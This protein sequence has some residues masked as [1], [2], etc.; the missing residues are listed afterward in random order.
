[1]S[2]DL[3]DRLK[4]LGPADKRILLAKLMDLRG[5][6]GRTAPLSYAQQRLWFLEQLI[7][8]NPFY[9][10][11]SAIRL[12]AAIDP[13][14]LQR[15]LNE[16]VRRHEALRT[17]FEAP[18][19]EPVQRVCP[20]MPVELPVIDLSHL[21]PA[22]REREA[23]R[24]CSEEGGRPFNLA[25]GPLLRVTLIKLDIGE[26]IFVLTMHHIVCDGWSMKVFFDEL[27]VLYEAMAGGQPSPLPEL[28]IQYVDFSIWQRGWLKG[29][30]L[31]Q[32]LAFW[33]M[34]LAG[35]QT[36]DL[37]TDHLRPAIPTFT[38]GRE[39]IAIAPAIYRNILTLCEQE[40][41]TPFM[42]LLASFQVLLARYSGQDD[43]AVGCPIANRNRPEVEKLIGFFVN[44]LVMRSDLSG[45]PTFRELLRR[46]R[47]VA[48]S[49]Y[50]HQDL[51]FEKLVEELQPTRD[52]SRNPLFQVTFQLLD[53]NAPAPAAQ[54]LLQTLEVGL[55]TSKFDLRCDLW[56]AGGG[57]RGHIEYSADL[58]EAETAR[59]L[60]DWL[61]ML[62]AAMA[63]SPDRRID[64]VGLMSA[65][66]EHKVLVAWN[67]TAQ[68]FPWQGC[69]HERFAAMAQAYPA[70]LAVAEGDRSRSYSELNRDAN[71]LAAELVRTGIRA[72]CLVPLVLDRSI[73]LIVAALAVL[74]AGAAYIP[75]DPTYPAAR[76]TQMIQQAMAPLVL[77]SRR[78]ID[79]VP[80]FLPR[81]CVD[82]DAAVAAIE[83]EN[84]PVLVDGRS[85]AYVIFTSGST[86]Q[87]RGVEITHDSLCNLV[88]WHQQA[89]AVTPQDRASLY[90]SPGFDASVWEIWPYLTAGASL[91]VTEPT[92]RPA[93]DALAR[94]MAG[95][96]ISISFLPTP[97]AETFVEC[98]TLP[99]LRVLLTGGDRLR[100]VPARSLPFRFVN[101]YG[102]TETTVVATCC[103]VA[104]KGSHGRNLPAIGRPIANTRAYVLDRRGRPVPPG[105]KG[106]LY[107]G[108]RSL[109]RG[110]LNGAEQTRERF[111]DD[112]FAP[113]TGERLYRTGDRVRMRHDGLLEFHGRIDSQIKLRGYRVEPGEI[114]AMLDQHPAVGKSLIVTQDDSAGERSLIAYLTPRRDPVGDAAEDAFAE[115]RVGE[116]QRIY[117]ELYDA[118]GAGRDAEFDI[119]GWNSSYTGAPLSADEMGEQV[120]GAVER[121][122]ALGGRRVLE[123]GCG[124]GLLLLRLADD[125]ERYVGTDFSAP[126]LKRL[127]ATVEARGWDHVELWER[128]AEDFGG[129]APGS[130]DVVVLNSVVQYFPDV[131][132]LVRVLREA[133]RVVGPT[134]SVFV[135]DVRH[136][137]LLPALHAEIEVR[138]AD[139]ASAAEIRERIARRGEQEQELVLD[140]AFF[141]ALSAELENC[142]GISIQI[143]RGWSHNELTRFRYDAL[144][145]GKDAVRRPQAREL[146]WD[147]IGNLAGLRRLLASTTEAVLIRGVPNA[148]LTEPCR[149][150]EGLEQADGA[151]PAAG[152]AQVADSHDGD[153]I[154]VEPEQLWQLGNDMGWDI[155]IGFAEQDPAGCDL[156]CERQAPGTARLGWS[157]TP[158][159]QK[160]PL[161]AYANTPTR[162]RT[163]QQL[164]ESLRRHLRGRLPGYMIPSSFVWLDALP[165]TPHGKL[166][167]RAL[168]VPDRDPG[169]E[170]RPGNGIEATLVEMWSDVL[171]VQR[172]GLHDNFFDIGGHSLMLVRL[173][174]RLT[175]S[176]DTAL[177]LVDL[178]RLPTVS[179][180]AR[181]LDTERSATA[182][183]AMLATSTPSFA[184]MTSG[185]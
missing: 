120:N 86:G 42:A 55:P 127:S 23:L 8:G 184:M 6:R 171:G 96:R 131:D 25:T 121:I 129:I 43:V 30:L 77:T 115:E 49:A 22:E 142:G 9:N 134:G 38:G 101:H 168:P 118:D 180:L 119:V 154:G 53:S 175:Q 54:P 72:G 139:G 176:F 152:L 166:N 130:F 57:I 94:W 95:Q 76:L 125:T 167:H 165:L 15:A 84:P 75:L 162:T 52:P 41:V 144:L 114:E 46:V 61:Q 31:E 126:A 35:L 68:D 136:L 79:S 172:V 103:D 174:R 111:I 128:T 56:V 17:C 100:A 48:I 145:H 183:G 80:A 149:L 81:L 71:R 13:V 160:L 104:S 12:L 124:T 99:P 63:A 67:D 148:R 60:A 5:A 108:G 117:D 7:G 91:H 141:A 3:V 85:L 65:H 164:T 185:T 106:E 44:T 34:R 122:G 62:I 182:A 157:V 58:F 10:E 113:G 156:H 36:L 89:Y 98:E 26:Q 140:P 178:Y 16:I 135:G 87:P 37:P 93:P 161:H 29:P 170:V 90:A 11:T 138:R 150:L 51:P 105:V 28:P 116:W 18:D 21:T 147:D 163:R 14:I 155:R 83:A 151:V 110:Y 88:D 92:V 179:A 59:S 173:H 133:M 19:G 40:G 66:Q 24:L 102:P 159:T 45:N 73:E 158:P 169:Q 64:T 109:A 181:A 112:P 2:S 78:H 27:A 20:M 74:K 177:G 153:A 82:A 137:P 132:Y 4:D 39:P 146:A 97:V 70:N 33:R 1:M 47:E 107:L 143:K 69:V 123:I 50:A 32:Q